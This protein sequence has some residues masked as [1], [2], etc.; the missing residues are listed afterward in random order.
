MGT[1]ERKLREKEQRRRMIIEAAERLFISR[2]YRNTTVD[3]IAEECEL[4]K[5]TL[6]LYFRNKDELYVW[7]II[8]IMDDYCDM[9][10]ESV[11]SKTAYPDRLQVL[12]DVFMEFYRKHPERFKMLNKLEHPQPPDIIESWELDQY[13]EIF[14]RMNRIWDLVVRVLQEGVDNGYFVPG[15]DPLE[16]GV[17]VWAS[18]LG[19]IHMMDHMSDPHHKALE[20]LDRKGCLGFQKLA[21][22]DFEKMLKHTWRGI[23][24][25]V[26]NNPNQFREMTS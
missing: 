10:E 14:C 21:K 22:L 8:T 18:S 12:G 9:V 5:G 19:I 24:L 16:I 20:G 25:Q 2:G 1:A 13:E 15:T 26:L 6:Y 4:S 11:A 7:V 3:D 23:F 17:N